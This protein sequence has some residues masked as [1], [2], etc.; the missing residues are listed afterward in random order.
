MGRRFASWLA[1]GLVALAMAAPAVAR[2]RATPAIPTHR[3]TA[4]PFWEDLQGSS[5]ASSAIV[6]GYSTS[7][8]MQRIRR[9]AFI[10]NGLHDTDRSICVS[11]RT[12]DGSYRAQFTIANPRLGHVVRLEVPSRHLSKLALRSGQLAVEARVSA[13]ATC[14]S[15]DPLVA[16][17]WSGDRDRRPTLSINPL[18]SDQT[19]V[20]V[21][22]GAAAPCRPLS[23]V[24]GNPREVTVAFRQL[25][26]V[27]VVGACASERAMTVERR[28]GATFLE[29]VKVRARVPCD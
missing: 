12:A 1:G 28:S 5:E 29:P 20:R 2:Q 13:A 11:A 7:P 23:A 16:V 3:V 10:L 14:T 19:S 24:T 22:K 26:A 21:D 27:P 4:P 9:S 6:T 8:P 25:C 18:L 15:A 17:Q